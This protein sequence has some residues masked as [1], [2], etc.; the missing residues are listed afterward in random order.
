MKTFT[1]LLFC[2]KRELVST[3]QK[4]V[5]NFMVRAFVNLF[6]YDIKIPFLEE[7]GVVII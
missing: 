4:I 2:G 7:K 5:N 6:K 3:N 1:F